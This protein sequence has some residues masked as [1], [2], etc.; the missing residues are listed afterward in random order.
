[1]TEAPC[2]V[3]RFRIKQ[4]WVTTYADAAT[5]HVRTA[6]RDWPMLLGLAIV[7]SWTSTTSDNNQG[8][9]GYGIHLSTNHFDTIREISASIR[10]VCVLISS[11]WGPLTLYFKQYPWNPINKD[12]N[13]MHAPQMTPRGNV[14]GEFQTPRQPTALIW[15]TRMW[16]YTCMYTCTHACMHVCMYVCMYVRRYVCIYVYKY[17]PDWHWWTL[18]ELTLTNTPY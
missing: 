7:S 3:C 17:G 13:D 5:E 18:R 1:M 6:L 8:F 12:V 16:M 11:N 14:G 10:C 2:L 9:Q 15:W 4:K